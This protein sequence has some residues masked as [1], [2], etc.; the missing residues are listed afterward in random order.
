MKKKTG[1]DPLHPGPY[2]R[3]NVL[4][5]GVNVTEAAAQLDVGRPALSNLLNGKAALSPDM[6]ARIERAFGAR[7]RDLLD[8][9]AAFDARVA[10]DKGAT[11]AVKPYV[12]PFL[13]FKSGDIGVWANSISSRSRFAVLL[14]TL[15]NSTGQQLERVEFP[16]NDNAERPGWDGLVEAREATPWI[17]PGKSGWEFGVK[18]DPKRK[19]D[20]DYTKSVAQTPEEERAEITFVFVTPRNWP[21]KTEWEKQRR[22]DGHWKEVRVFDASDL[23]AW[24]EQSIPAQAWL[25]NERGIPSDG[26]L[27]LDACWREWA[28]DCEP[29]PVTT[30]FDPAVASA[31]LTVKSR[32]SKDSSEPIV[33]SADSTMEAMAFLHCLFSPDNPDISVFRDRIAVFT[34]PGA[35]SR[36]ASASSNFIAVAACRE[37]ERE[38]AQHKSALRSVIIYPRNATNADPDIVLEPLNHESF[39]KALQEM[40]CSRDDIQRY[41][42]ESGHSPTVLRRRLSKLDAIRTPPWAADK[43]VAKSLIP[44]LFAGSWKANNQADQTILELLADNQSFSK[45]ESDLASL[46]QLDDSPV[47]SVGAF[48]GLVSKIDVLFAVNK[49]IIGDEIKRFLNVAKLVLSEDDP[50]LELPEDER[51][52]AGIHGKVREIS[53]ALRDGISETLVLVSTHGTSLFR[54]RLGIDPE[55]EVGRVIQSLLTPLTSRALEAHSGDLPMYAEAAPDV[56]LTMLEE[57]LNS[58]DPQ[59]LGLM[60]P[61]GTGIF[62]RCPRTGLLWALENLAWSPDYLARTVL[63]L[64]RLAQPVI[65]DNWANKPSKSLSAIFRCWMPQTAASLEKRVAT[66]ELL[67]EKLPKVAWRICME[68]FD[69]S[70]RIG[71][72]SHKPRWRTDGHGFGEPLPTRNLVYVFA[73]HALDMALAWESHDR[74]MLGD[75]VACANDLEAEDRDAIWSLIEVWSKSASD[76][77]K[78]WIREKIRV[79]AFTRRAIKRGEKR[80]R[81]DETLK[82]ARQVYNSLLPSDVNFKHEWLFRNH[83]VEESADELEDEDLDHREREKRITALRTDALK[84]IFEA[85]GLDG[86]LRV[87]EMGEASGVIGWLLP[88]ILE[89]PTKIAEVLRTLAECNPPLSESPSRRSIISGALQDEHAVSVLP[90][91]IEGM[92]ESEVVSVISLAPFSRPTWDLL[93]TLEGGVQ[94]R[95]WGEISPQWFHS[96]AEDLQF[97]VGK[98][99]EVNRPKAAFQLIRCDIEGIQ[100]RVL[101]RALMEIA[102]NSQ[103]EAGTYQFESYNIGQAFE[104]LNKSGEIDVDDMAALE[105][106]YIEV[107]DRDEGRIPNLDLQLE[108]HPE[109]FVQAV[110]LAYKRDDGGEDPEHFRQPDQEQRKHRAMSAYRLLERLSRIP[111][112]N[113]EG[114][115]DAQEIQAWVRR[116]RGECAELA[117]SNVCDLSLGKLFSTA[118]VGEDDVWPC[119]PVRDALETLAT[120][121]LASGI[122]NSLYN[123]RG[124]HFRGEDGDGERQ[125]AE[126]YR[127]WAQA[128]EFTHPRVAKIMQQMVETYEREAKSHDTEAGVRKR[129]RK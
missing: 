126:K 74:E 50:S 69:G 101:F 118:S 6:A 49:D 125:L 42:H 40:G 120:D 127:K 99:L 18:K 12:P 110:V 60:R 15:I 70:Q 48:R 9:Q 61:A 119:K 8:M 76:E 73:R 83:W 94:T 5:D 75:L 84:E 85:Q 122:R 64:G 52:A 86:I 88:K 7:A 17:P 38:L 100:P 56:F 93:G 51:W 22:T 123:S 21:G 39:D 11:T 19:A 47:W 46:A 14:R 104:V 33:I 26:V 24:L 90:V 92:T 68:Q 32:F 20:G 67:A 1:P 105:F 3:A 78:G 27:S 53:A 23:E 10:K 116:V 117:R 112:R 55:V 124:F 45:L 35:L 28:A 30:L 96:S 34:V 62:G 128:L 82:R 71:D 2:I 107:F 66:L 109:L 106:R 91:L 58:G 102:S 65:N 115:L 4:P 108:K 113:R 72:Y 29:A 87:A 95:Y 31:R 37:V 77:D 54:E 36:L 114:E 81:D 129:L 44:F 89:K 16:G 59:S 97:A 79:S 98:L 57:D 80:G 43:A 111:G 63:V 121:E 41:A 103:E 25:A 13:Q